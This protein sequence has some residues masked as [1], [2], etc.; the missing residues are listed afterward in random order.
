MRKE[1][2]G[3]GRKR[4]EEKKEKRR[5]EK[6]RKEKK[7]KEK[8]RKEKK[9]KEKHHIRQSDWEPGCVHNLNNHCTKISNHYQRSNSVTKI[10]REHL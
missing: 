10:T 3:K 8:K 2:K 6:K 9:R 4:K 5:E 7:R 1:K